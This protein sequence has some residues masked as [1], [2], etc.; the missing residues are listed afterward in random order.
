MKHVSRLQFKIPNRPPT[1]EF[2]LKVGAW[3]IRFR[4]TKVAKTLC[5]DRLGV[6]STIDLD[7]K[8]EVVGLEL[9]GVREFSIKLARKLAPVDISNVDFERAKFVHAGAC[10]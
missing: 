1:V 8:N 4:N 7:A 9:I 3:Y 5:D 6:I 10:A 2:D